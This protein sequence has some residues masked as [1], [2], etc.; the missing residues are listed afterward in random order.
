[1]SGDTRR[2][3]Y[4][5][6]E[7]AQLISPSNPGRKPPAAFL[8]RLRGLIAFRRNKNGTG[9]LKEKGGQWA[10]AVNGRYREILF[11]LGLILLVAII[12]SGTLL[13]AA[14]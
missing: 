13:L 3:I 9:A 2:N 6:A 14:M 4:A 5:L 7:A 12:V 10:M 1:V 11:Y 8:N